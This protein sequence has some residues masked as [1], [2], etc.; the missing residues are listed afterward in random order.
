[1]SVSERILK[2]RE[3]LNL[4]QTDLAKRAGLKPPAISQYESG[5]RSPSYEALIKLS[6]A[7]DVT[8]D[9]LIS[10]KEVKSD[11]INDKTIKVLFKILPNLSVENKDKL[12]E[13]AIFLSSGSHI[14]EV[15]IMDETDYADYVLKNY[16]NNELP[17]DVYTIAEKL[18]IVIF[19]DELDDGEGIL[20]QS[21]K[22][23]II[24][25]SRVANKQRRKFTIAILIGH[26]LIPWHVQPTYTVR[27]TGS[28][29]LLTDSIQEMEAQNF[30]AGLIMP[31]VH[32]IKDFIKTRASIENLKKL[33]I[34][35][36]DVS[37]FSLANRLVDYSKD[38]Y[39]VIQSGNSEILKTFQGNRPI[40]EK[41]D[42]KSIATTFFDNPSGTEEI[43]Q[44]KVLA[45]HWLQDANND[46]ML[47][48]ESIYNP[49]YK[50]VLT[51]LTIDN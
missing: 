2:K 39:A 1:M 29:T 20:V 16:T 27:K 7:L 15:P 43:R 34:D 22:K 48:E 10:G 47:Y 13:Y 4:S 31:Q 9:Y 46:E 25:D 8:T 50:K 11:K 26:A 44:G 5:S 36:Y 37:L 21:E 6:N 41:L 3:D 12:L 35:K 24:L 17:I 40:V 28:S 30:A 38:K 23:V 42:S 33:A 45:K 19:E 18:N 32:L 14:N 49:E 51:L